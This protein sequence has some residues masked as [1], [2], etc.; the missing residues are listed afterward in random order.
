VARRV[1]VRWEWEAREWDED[2]EWEG[3]GDDTL[4]VGLANGQGRNRVNE[5]DA[6]RIKAAGGCCAS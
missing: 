6:W 1:V 4:R 5:T 2:G 3:R